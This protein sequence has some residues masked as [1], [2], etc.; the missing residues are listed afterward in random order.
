MRAIN[1][2]G[3][4]LTASF[5]GTRLVPYQDIAGNWTWG[6]GH[7]QQP[8]EQ[9]PIEITQ[10]QCNALFEKD[11]AYAASAVERLVTVE[12]GDNMFAALVDFCFN[13]GSSHFA[14]STLLKLLNAGDFA[15]AAKQFC[16][17]I[18]SGNVISDGLVRRRVAERDLF[19]TPDIS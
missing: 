19:L 4:D 3:Q 12:T 18:Y 1:Q 17:W 13:I 11:I 14:T 8:G 7:K 6:V 15:G 16:R 10:D 5:E 2:A 9:V